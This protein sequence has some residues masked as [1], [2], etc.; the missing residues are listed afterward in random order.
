VSRASTAARAATAGTAAAAGTEL[1]DDSFLKK[2]EYLYIVS[3]KVFA[4]RLRAERRTKKTGSG[5]E[6]ADHRDYAAGDDFRYI[7]WKI[8][9]RSD[10]L[11]LRLFEEEEDLNIYLLLDASR[12]MV[13]GLHAAGQGPVLS[14]LAYA[15]QVVA[16][17]GY[18]GLCNLDR[19]SVIP[20]A[21]QLSMGLPPTR[22]K[23][24]IFKLFEHLR[25]VKAD[26][27]T[28][29]T[30]SLGGFV[31]R[32]KRR[33]LAVVLS[34]FFDPKG[35]AEGLNFL[36]YHRFEPMVIQVVDPVDFSPELR[37]DLSL[38]DCETGTEREVT[39][40]AKLLEA[41]LAEHERYCAEL[42]E[43]CTR[44]QIPYFRAD[45]A[46][47]FDELVLKIFRA[48]GFVK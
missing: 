16:A 29:L 17:L 11:L 36:R 4:G 25:G 44:S 47:P 46:V 22:G 6:F 38:V 30:A 9:G 42:L 48:G 10:R 45:T 28:D 32:Y 40:T 43:F 20:F 21:G 18:V 27:Q 31:H 8:Y 1:F 2:L 41:Y 23:S 26:G 13:G 14:K 7:D 15:Q 5:V 19:V 34:D 24:R 39:I 37:G 33:G 35:Y 3:K 12:S